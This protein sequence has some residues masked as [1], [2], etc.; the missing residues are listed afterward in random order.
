MRAKSKRAV[1]F[2]PLIIAVLIGLSF[3]KPARIEYHKWR[4]TAAKSE[5]QRLLVGEH[6]LSDTLRE[7]LTA[8]PVTWQE[9]RARWKRHEQALVDLGYL[10]RV[11]YYA[12]RGK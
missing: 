3:S 6:R 11:E 10:G 5:Y 9:V 1:V 12:R 7:L 2:A 8:K 4:V